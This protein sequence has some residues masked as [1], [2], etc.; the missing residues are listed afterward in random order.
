LRH[1]LE[2]KNNPSDKQAT[3]ILRLPHIRCTTDQKKGLEQMAKSREL[4]IWRIKRAKIILGALEGKTLENLVVNVRVPPES[5]V[6][7]V[8][9]FSK[10]GIE[11]LRHPTRKPTKRE[12]L[13]EKM[14]YMLEKASEQKGE[15]WKSF[16]VRYIGIDF[17]GPMIRKI[18]A[19]IVAHPD[20]TRTKLS[21]ILCKDFGLYSPTGI[22]KEKTIIDILKRMDMDNLIRLPKTPTRT[23][24][25]AHFSKK[26]DHPT[27]YP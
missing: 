22:P 27:H 12:A 6:K 4:G 11:S 17:T 10:E 1:W 21:R 24:P 14:L 8:A 15:R 7:C 26:K 16:A 5:I 23:S 2:Q 9:A 19:L 3:T 20:A 25:R 18:R 13:V